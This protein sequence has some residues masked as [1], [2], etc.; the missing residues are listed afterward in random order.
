MR[1]VV[2]S[3][4]LALLCLSAAVVLVAAPARADEAP[5]ADQVVS[6]MKAALEPPKPSIRTMTMTLDDQGTE[7]TF[8]LVQARKRLADG[9]RAL[10]VLFA[11]AGARGIAYLT[12]EGTN[13][14]PTEWLY[15]PYVQRARKLVPAEN[16]QS[17]MDTDFTYGDL[18]LLPVDTR[19]TLLGTETVDGK[20]AYKVESIPSTTVKQWYYSR[21]V[22]WID[23][24]TLLP[25]RRELYSP[26]GDLFKVETS[27]SVTRIEG[28]PTPLEIRITDVGTKSTT[29]LKVDSVNYDAVVP[30]ALFQP[31]GLRSIAD[32]DAWKSTAAAKPAASK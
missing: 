16:Y 22:T 30:D 23:A 19:N 5:T 21:A 28:I 12:A 20:K 26:A 10:T 14:G 11:P 27:G 2:P 1:V 25:T 29:T 17:F 24:A 4:R 31:D 9:A 18:G 13:G 3:V 32:A 6:Q 8:S 15:V 7:T